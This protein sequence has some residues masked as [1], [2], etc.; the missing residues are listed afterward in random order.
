MKR[1]KTMSHRRGDDTLLQ[2]FGT[3]HDYASA[4][5]AA[6]AAEQSCLLRWRMRVEMQSPQDSMLEPA[7]A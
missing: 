5:D 6:R 7:F 2:T 4:N 1:L 3:M